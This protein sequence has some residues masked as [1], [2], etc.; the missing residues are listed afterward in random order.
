MSINKK[1][2]ISNEI[3]KITVEPLEFPGGNLFLRFL[4][5]IVFNC[6]DFLESLLILSNNQKIKEKKVYLSGEVSFETHDLSSQIGGVILRCFTL[7]NGNHLI[8]EGNPNPFKLH[9]FDSKWN[10][11]ISNEP[12]RF[13][14]WHGTWSISQSKFGSVIF[15]EYPNEFSSQDLRVWKSVD[16]GISWEIVFLLPGIT[17]Q[18]DTQSPGIVR[19]F[20]TCQ[21]YEDDG[22]WIVSTGDY[23][24]HCRQF[25]SYDD[26]ITWHEKIVEEVLGVDNSMLKLSR[27]LR[28]TCEASF[29]KN[30]ICWATDDTVGLGQ[31]QFV[32]CNLRSPVKISFLG[33]IGSN[34]VRSLV[35]IGRAFFLT[36][37]ES[38]KGDGLASIYLAGQDY[39]PS[40]VGDI[41][42]PNIKTG[43]TYSKCSKKVD[44][45]GTFYTFVGDGVFGRE[46]LALQWNRE[47]LQDKGRVG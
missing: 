39:P 13:H 27:G 1:I 26:G 32:L 37:P 35:D 4:E 28:R 9:L 19:H 34:E 2:S 40:F 20:H 42:I 29:D 3:V 7:S 25:F 15:V 22:V 41:L 24:L 21:F 38:K 16:G 5:H 47:W 11:I 14:A 46:V 12:G 44:R 36:I 31:S 18:R 10:H 30:T 8:F 33:G 43:F 23:W 6:D 45:N 17:T